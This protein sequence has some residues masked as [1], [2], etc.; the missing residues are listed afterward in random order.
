M[1]IESIL[2]I[3]GSIITI[4]AFVGFKC[5]LVLRF[6]KR[7]IGELYE[8]LLDKQITDKQRRKILRRLN[9]YPEIN[10]RIKDEY[11]EH[12]TL[13][14]LG[15]ETLFHDICN[16]NDIEPT[17]ALIKDV[18][19]YNMSSNTTKMENLKQYTKE[20][21]HKDSLVSSVEK[22]TSDN[23]LKSF[24]EQTVYMSEML[25][26]KFPDACN[27][28]IGIL[29]KHSVKYAF[30][31]GTNDIWCRDYM[32]IQTESGKFIQF[33]YNPSYLKGNKDWEESRSDVEKVCRMNNIHAQRS[34]INL[35]GGNVLICEGRA[36]LSDRIF[37]ENP[38][39]TRQELIDELSKLLECEIIIIKALNSKDEDFTGHADGMVRFV[40]K[41]TILGNRLVDDYKYIQDDRR[42]IIEKYNLKYIDVPF[43]TTVNRD[44]AIGIYLNYLEVN[45]LIVVPVFGRDEDKQAVDIIQ[46]AFPNKVIETINYDEVALE[47]GLL[48]CTTWVIK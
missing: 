11:I 4:A 7:P 21:L 22:E 18:V 25:M 46:K 3:A 48:N 42:K 29:E 8:D 28:L 23:T 15:R 34:D 30:L 39:K 14:K 20:E 37:S 6:K 10:K 36:I 41:N 13:G 1:G 44:S 17:P 31:K 5:D 12:F 9:N 32:P 19:G 45:D 43:F 40:N 24:K 47:G 27:R 35:D 26:T 2:G 16:K 38:E 33:Q